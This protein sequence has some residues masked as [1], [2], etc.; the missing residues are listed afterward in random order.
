MSKLPTVVVVG[1]GIVGALTATL[2]LCYNGMTLLSASRGA[3]SKLDANKELPYFDAAFYGMSAVCVACYVGLLT[4]SVDLI[5]TRLR[6]LHFLIGI[7]I[8]EVAYF[9]AVAAFWLQPTIG[10]SVGAATG[11]ANGG[12][13][14]Q[15]G[16]LF[17]FWAPIAL[18]WA[19]WRLSRGSES[20]R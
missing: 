19:R 8:F 20:V 6:W 11:V 16:I 3:F 18:L 1:V 4:C 13:M 5:R 10:R 7:F 9:L 2:G 12:M 17:P 15:L 14:A